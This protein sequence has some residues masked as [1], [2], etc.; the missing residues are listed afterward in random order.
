MPLI[1]HYPFQDNA[2]EVVSGTYNGTVTGATLTA[3]GYKFANGDSISTPAGTLVIADTLPGFSVSY[4]V[5]YDSFTNDFSYAIHHNETDHNVAN[6]TIF[7]G[8]DPENRIVGTLG[9]VDVLWQ[10]G[11]TQVHPEI[12]RWYHVCVVW[13][14]TVQ[15]VTVYVDN[16]PV[17]SYTLTTITTKTANLWL[18]SQNANYRFMNGNVYDVRF[19]D[20]ALTLP[21]RT[22]LYEFRSMTSVETTDA[23]NS[24]ALHYDFKDYQESTRNVI[25]NVNLHTGW[26]DSYT[27]NRLFDDIPP[28]PGVSS[29]VISFEN[30]DTDGDGYWYS[31]GDYAPQ[32]ASTTYTIS[33]WVKTNQASNVIIRAYTADNSEL[34]RIITGDLTVNA[35]EGWK[36]LVWTITTTADNESDSLSFRYLG[37]Y[38]DGYTRL[39]MCAP[40]ME[41]LDH[42]TL[43]TTKDR[44]S[45]V[46][47]VSGNGNKGI[48]SIPTP[49]W[50]AAGYFFGPETSIVTPSITSKDKMTLCFWY[51]GTD[52]G[53]WRTFFC[54]NNGARHHVLSETGT[55]EL[56]FF[57]SENPGF[58]SSG[59]VMPENE[60][61]HYAIVLEKNGFWKLYVDTVLT[62]TIAS[63]MFDISLLDNG[64]QTIGNHRPD[65]LPGNP[66][67]VNGTMDDIKI[68]TKELTQAELVE[69][70]ERKK[71]DIIDSTGNFSRKNSEILSHDKGLVAWYPLKDDPHN[72]FGGNGDDISVVNA[73]TGYEFNGTSAYIIEEDSPKLNIINSLTLSVW[74]YA[75]SVGWSRLVARAT[76]NQWQIDIS[77]SGQF[78]FYAT[79]T[80]R[81]LDHSSVM[82]GVDNQTNAW[83]H[84]VGTYDNNTMRLYIN[85]VLAGSTIV[86]G[87]LATWPRANTIIGAGEASPGVISSTSHFDGF[88]ADVRIWDRDLSDAEV[89]ALYTAGIY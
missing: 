2:N 82:S 84:V 26:T 33:V 66:Q 81:Y 24:L 50:S 75:R 87:N 21:E 70:Y 68:F 62:A 20:H 1:L 34:G 40:Q 25:T 27:Q 73:A 53:S 65:P 37:L 28:P 56:G 88:I 67:H 23:T 7:C 8:T 6:S 60:L 15:L 13:D 38:E 46:A 74:A 55:R 49:V 44:V 10:A 39:W 9:S 45:F 16:Q 35:S 51:Q 86:G 61:H 89:L 41:A 54:R 58:V 57:Y 76:H 83:Y 79:T 31:Y 11:R 72:A 64:V 78:R 47:D 85:G 71:K 22:S 42:D 3:R 14:R 19:Y 80:E 17:H 4:W 77:S 18:G 32:E 48:L 36:R 59:Y 12:G 5:Q 30:D 63:G 69:V 43:F 52:H 29:P